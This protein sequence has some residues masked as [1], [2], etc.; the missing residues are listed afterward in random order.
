MNNP[1]LE[2]FSD[3]PPSHECQIWRRDTREVVLDKIPN[4]ERAEKLLKEKYPE[5]EQREQ[6]WIVIVNYKFFKGETF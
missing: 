2:P 6:F 1:L 3:W 5:K 4:I